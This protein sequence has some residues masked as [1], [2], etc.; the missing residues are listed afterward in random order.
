MQFAIEAPETIAANDRIFRAR[1]WF[2]YEH[3][4][5]R[6]LDVVIATLGLV[7]GLPLWLAIA[8]AIKLDSPGPVLHVQERVGLNGRRFRFYKF[9]SMYSDAETRLES[10]LEH[11]EPTAPVFNMRTDP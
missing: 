2:R 7:G 1:R 11:N 10:L 8:I 3:G 9:R 6:F 5:K 4:L